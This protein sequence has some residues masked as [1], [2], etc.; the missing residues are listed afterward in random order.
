MKKVASVIMVGFLLLLSACSG[1]ASGDGEGSGKSGT[2]KVGALYP[3]SGGLALLGEESFRGAE[4]AI[5]EANKNG[6]IAGGKKIELVKGDAVDADAAQAEANRLINQENIKTIVGS[7][8]SSIAFA[9]SEVAER[10]GVLYWELGAVSD[11][12][13]DRKYKYVVRTNPPASYF[14]KVHVDFIKEIVTK[15][16]GKE[17]GDIKVGLAYEDSTY[18]TTIADEAAKLAKKEGINVVTKQAYSAASNDLSSV[19][20][21]LKKAAPDVLIAVSYLNDAVLLARQS[22]ELGLKVPVFVGSGG[23]H[24]MTDFEDAMGEKA[25]GILNIDFPQYQINREA[26][27]GIEEFMALY[28]EKYGEDPRS[29]H[30][31]T[32][33]MGM[34]IVLDVMDKVGEVD[35]D[36]LKEEA[37]KYT[38]DPG[39]TVTGWGVEFDQ[40]TGQNKLGQ[41]YVHQW[42]NGELKTVW[43]ENVAVEEP[44]IANK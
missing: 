42:L 24:T 20:L 17:L 33:Y 7:Y 29:G 4:L 37:L 35:P 14:S 22:E 10:S 31:L 8:S 32:N 23:G 15:K 25:N 38:A 43:P 13:T 28:K 16:L 12:I 2:L 9:A 27:P 6:G 11:T 19:V 26:T 36:K 39:S 21:N 1:G 18:G 30:S 3:L 40:D 34:K 5:E 41:P 44:Q